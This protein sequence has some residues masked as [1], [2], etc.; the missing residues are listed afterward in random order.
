[1]SGAYIAGGYTAIERA[2]T[3]AQYAALYLT[4]TGSSGNQVL[5]D[6]NYGATAGTVGSGTTAV[7]LAKDTSYFTGNVAIGGTTAATKLEVNTAP[8]SDAITL[9]ASTASSLGQTTG[10]RFQYNAAVPAAI[11]TSMVSTN[12]GAA[13]LGFF[14][15]SDGTVGNLTNRFE[16]SSTGTQDHKANS[17]VNSASIQGLQDSGACYDFDGTDGYI[18]VGSGSGLDNLTSL[19]L[20][21]WV[22]LDG[23]G[24][25][26]A[27]RIFSKTS[28]GNTGGWTVYVN[29]AG[30]VGLIDDWTTTDGNYISPVVFSLSN[31]THVAVTYDRSSA[32][33]A[34]TFYVNGVAITLSS[35]TAS[36]GAV[37]SDTGSP[38]YIGARKNGSAIDREFEGQIRDFKIFPSVLDDDDVRKLYSGENPKKNLNVELVTNGDFADTTVAADGTVGGWYNGNWT[39]A[40]GV[41]TA[42]S[43]SSALWQKYALPGADRTY[44]YAFDY[45]RTDSN[46]GSLVFQWHNGS[47][48]ITLATVSNDSGKAEGTFTVGASIHA[49]RGIYFQATTTWEGTI[50]N[51]SIT[52]VGTL[53]DFSP[54]SASSTKWHNQAIP[55]LYHGT[56][57]GGVTLSAGSTDHRVDG[58]LEVDGDLTVTSGNITAKNSSDNLVLGCAA[59][60]NMYLGGGNAN[61]QNIIL[62]TGT[63]ERMRIDST[64]DTTL[65]GDLGIGVSPSAWH[66]TY[67]TVD[68]NTGGGI[69]GTT[70]GFGLTSNVYLNQTSNWIT[71]TSGS[72]GNLF[73]AYDAKYFWYTFA[74]G[75]AGSAPNLSTRMKLDT[76]GLKVYNNLGV[77]GEPHSVTPFTVSS[78]TSNIAQLAATT[79]YARL[80]VNAST[81]ACDAQVAFQAEGTTKWSIGNDA[82]DSHKFKIQ[83]AAGVF[84]ASTKF[85][86]DASGNCGIGTDSPSNKLVVV[87]SDTDATTTALLQNSSTG[88]ASLH[89]NVSG[90]SY[91]VGIDNSDDDKF[92]ISRNNGLGTTDRF[93]IDGEGTQNHYGNRIVNSQ[94]LNDS[95]RT[96]EPSLRFGATGNNVALP[97]SAYDAVKGNTITVGAWIKRTSDSGAWDGIVAVDGLVNQAEGFS[98]L[99]TTGDQLF[100]QYD[101][102]ADQISGQSGGQ[103]LALNVWYHVVGTY[104]GATLKT[105]VNGVLDRSSAGAGKSIGATSKTIAIGNQGNTTSTSSYFHGEIKDARIHNRALDADEV[106]ASYNGESTPFKYADAAGEKIKGV[107]VNF[108]TACANVGA[109]NTAYNGSANGNM[110]SSGPTAPTIVVASNAATITNTSTDSGNGS[111][112]RFNIGAING[113]KYRL[114]L[115]VSA[116]TGTF[117]VKAYNGGWVNL[118]TINSTGAKNFELD[119]W[120]YSDVSLYLIGGAENNAITITAGTI[121]NSLAQ[122]GEVAAYTPRSINDKWYDETSNAN[123]G[124]IAGATAVG[125]NDH[126]GYLTVKGN[127][128]QGTH[129]GNSRGAI[130]LGDQPLWRGVLDYDSNLATSLRIDN[131]YNNAGA[132]TSFGMNGGAGTR[133]PVLELT[134]DGSV[135]STSG[136]STNLMQVARVSH[137]SFTVGTTAAANGATKTIWNMTH[138]LGTNGVVVSVRE[139]SGILGTRT[140]VETLVH[141]GEYWSTSGGAWAASVNHVA[142]EFASSPADS[143]VYDVTITG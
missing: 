89:F 14:T 100:W 33:Q 94:T 123:H 121:N 119:P 114:K 99:L 65:T 58:D 70:N 74:S 115:N 48:Y 110:Y 111:G 117:Y 76:T 12:S 106:A 29:S 7:Q 129:S 139:S 124:T 131:T 6:F 136:T 75:N 62:Q 101:G 122:I 109:F 98:L 108:A 61:T 34:P 5:A 91:T 16:I 11:R 138:Q 134:G 90:R 64:G 46:S 78:A 35:T 84:G 21:A 92:K 143:T 132:K 118:E 68:L 113:K 72:A 41:V 105:Y 9:R 79:T 4:K 56:L 40:S 63:S 112:I 50:D 26:N 31:W 59:I 140:L 97:T 25:G 88:D 125:D 127:T 19:T 24:E 71:K 51:V 28:T 23:W 120:A 141:T 60:G 52:E 42:G 30:Q 69:H 37:V 38:A 15:A 73:A 142:I 10:I 32:G 83:T 102:T 96:A 13:D 81:N 17:I 53:V 82:G 85:T 107:G 133:L 95:H 77:G 104:D 54:R 67:A 20:S 116:I 86:L 66:S 80:N 57:N 43:T 3:S 44:H 135:K 126:R 87:N 93:A 45:N 130:F 1:M 2:T 103:I 47:S 39:I 49:N 55:S 137:H 128:T 18:D 27:G 8:N 22:R 36:V